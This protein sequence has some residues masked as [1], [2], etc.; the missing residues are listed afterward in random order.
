MNQLDLLGISGI[1]N[2]IAAIKFAKY[3][4]L[5]E[6]DYVVT[7]LTDSMELY[8]SRVE[9]LAADRGEYTNID[10][11][12]D[13]QLLMDSGIE[14]MLEL[15]HYEKKRVHNLKYFTWIEQQG[16]ELDE[17]NE[18]WYD[19]DAYWNNI[20]SLAPQIDELIVEFNLQ[21]DAAEFF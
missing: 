11:H 21:I 20:F 16:R 13:V 8:G 18:Q 10:A 19:H 15:T 2:V 5:T 12:K 4:E 9:E 6:D 3:Y 14:N 17:L 1:G 7:I